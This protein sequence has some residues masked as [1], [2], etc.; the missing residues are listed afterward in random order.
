MNL[1]RAKMQE[2]KKELSLK[3]SHISAPDVDP[4]MFSGIRRLKILQSKAHLTKDQKPSVTITSTNIDFEHHEIPLV[5]SE[6]FA[7]LSQTASIA[8]GVSGGVLLLLIAYV[9]YKYLKWK[10]KMVA[11]KG[12]RAVSKS[13]GLASASENAGDSSDG[14]PSLL[15]ASAK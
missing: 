3:G 4:K 15:K 14:T 5:L 12:Y 8:I 2:L 6:G 13:K 11:R 9:V 1:R 7:G 10:P